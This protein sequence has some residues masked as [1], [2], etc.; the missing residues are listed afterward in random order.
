[1]VIKQLSVFVENTPG[2][3]ER[4]T[5]VLMDNNINIDSF[6]LADTSDYGVLRMI[7]SN[8]ELGQ[9]VLKKEGFSAMLTEVLLVNIPQS[10]G[11]L[12]KILKLLYEESISVEYMYTLYTKG[13]DTSIIMKVSD[14]ELGNKVLSKI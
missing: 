3:L 1:M 7:V 2:R 6:S 14:I 12:H 13:E 10:P 5:E 11:T 8:G 4:V 9:E